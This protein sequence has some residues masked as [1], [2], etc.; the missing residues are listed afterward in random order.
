[1]RSTTRSGTAGIRT[2]AISETAALAVLLALAGST[3]ASQPPKDPALAT[4]REIRLGVLVSESTVGGRA[5]ADAR[6]TA[7]LA[8]VEKRL[9]AAGVRVTT[10]A[11]APYLN[12]QLASPNL[13]DDSGRAGPIV[14]IQAT[15]SDRVTVARAGGEIH[16][17]A[18]L[19]D[20]SDIDA[21]PADKREA[22]NRLV[23]RTLNAFLRAIGIDPH[24][25]ACQ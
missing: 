7:I 3:L 19:W 23:E 20:S 18:H 5:G 24:G 21:C 9:Q 14:T 15:L 4:I 8:S 1:M 12:I 22:S 17:T 13:C 2:S 10:D 11:A 25:R 6:R 16:T